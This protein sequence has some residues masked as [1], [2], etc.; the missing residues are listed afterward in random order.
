MKAVFRC[1]VHVERTENYKIAKRVYV[2][3][4]AGS[5]SVVRPR[6]KWI[7]TVKHY[8]KKI[9]MDVRRARRMMQDRSEWHGFVRGNACGGARG[10]NP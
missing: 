1:F 8:L 5:P 10:M 7:D 3:E 6:K 4:C 9:G 2:E